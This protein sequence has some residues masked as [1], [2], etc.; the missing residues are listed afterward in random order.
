MLLFCFTF[1]HPR[2]ILPITIGLF[3]S[4][5]SYGQQ[6]AGIAQHMANY[7]YQ[8][9]L[10]EIDALENDSST[11]LLLLKGT[12]YK[13]L[14]QY[15]E[16]VSVFLQLHK[17]DPQNIAILHNL[18]TCYTS[19]GNLNAAIDLYKVSLRTDSTNL[20]L[21]QQLA[22][23]NYQNEDYKAAC[24][25]YLRAYNREPGHY[26]AN[27]L[28]MC[29]DKL[30]DTENAL[31]YSKIALEQSPE[32]FYS[33]Y[34]LASL[35]QELELYDAGIAVADN[36]LKHDPAKLKMLQLKAYLLYLKKEYNSSVDGF[37][38]CL[39]IGDTSE[40]TSKYLGY[41]YFNLR[42]F[43]TAIPYFKTALKTDSTNS[44]L[45]YRTGLSY[46]YMANN[47]AA[48]DCLNKVLELITPEATLLADIHENL[49]EIQ[50]GSFQPQKALD[51]FLLANKLNPSDTVLLFKIAS[52][53]QY[54]MEDIPKALLYYQ[55]FIDTRPSPT[56]KTA[57]EDQ[58]NGVSHY[59]V[60]YY[61]VA[62]S[63]MEE[64]KKEEFW[65]E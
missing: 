6:Y 55:K 49:G 39:L 43:E 45:Y 32:D 19:L 63:R 9:A 14:H 15:K 47:R 42:E 25:Y 46:H 1:S 35:Y 33:A 18:A 37:K 16:A 54:W 30:K 59:E 38:K 8:E 52:H 27:K 64:L 29:Y 10:K 51:S 60:S 65:G 21:M 56:N 20:F 5:I 2:F 28:R 61:D 40:F 50:T 24:D 58:Q 31:F 26:L 44:N 17:R 41:N 53:Y 7:Q 62:I 11:E 13:A 4:L 34:R 48:E 36:Y 23:V 12:A 3:I 57:G 22:N